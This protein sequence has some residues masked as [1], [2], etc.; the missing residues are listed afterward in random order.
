MTEAIKRAEREA[1]LAM[2][3]EMARADGQVTLAADRNYQER[4]FIE[5]LRALGVIPL[6]AE[7]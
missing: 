2:M 1:G 5:G 7:Y 6:V 3:S 4:T